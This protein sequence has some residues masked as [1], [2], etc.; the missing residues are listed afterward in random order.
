MTSKQLRP[1]LTH[2]FD[3]STH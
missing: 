3:N 1:L 2:C